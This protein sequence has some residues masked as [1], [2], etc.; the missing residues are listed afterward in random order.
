MEGHGWRNS[1]GRAPGC[2]S[3]SRGQMRGRSIKPRS[4]EQRSSVAQWSSDWT[5]VRGRDRTWSD[6]TLSSALWCVTAGVHIT[7]C[8]SS[9]H[10]GGDRQ[11]ERFKLWNINDISLN[12]C[13]APESYCSVSVVWQLTGCYGSSR[14]SGTCRWWQG[15]RRWMC[16][17]VG[18]CLGSHLL[19]MVTRSDTRWSIQHHT[20]S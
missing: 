19:I 1:G 18:L 14:G 5:D 4:P 7:G 3:G 8:H 2:S 17:M 9:H 10:G 13:P 6:P 11:G 12:N 20:Q 15:W 16:W